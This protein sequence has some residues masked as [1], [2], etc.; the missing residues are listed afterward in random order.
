MEQLVS[1]ADVSSVIPSSEQRWGLLILDVCSYSAAPAGMFCRL[2]V[3][4][5]RLKRRVYSS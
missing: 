3:A 4:G 1:Q 2:Q 5:C